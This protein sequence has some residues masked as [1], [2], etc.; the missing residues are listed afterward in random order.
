MQLYPKKFPSSFSTVI[1]IL[2]QKGPQGLLSGL[3][4]RM[5]RRTLMA[6]MAWTVYE[7]TM[8]SIGLK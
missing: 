4:P 7:Q 8:K 6:S 1:Y 5:M 3:A 2:K